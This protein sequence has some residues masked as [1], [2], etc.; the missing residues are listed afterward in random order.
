MEL[1]TLTPAQRRLVDGLLGWSDPRPLA[2]DDQIERLRRELADGV[3]AILD[4][5][6]DG[7]SVFVGKTGLDRLACDGWW[8]DL[9]DDRFVWGFQTAR[10][11]LA[12]AAIEWDWQLRRGWPP[13]VPVARAW[14]Q[15]ATGGDSLAR[16]LN[17]LDEVDATALRHQAEQLTTDLR[18]TWPLLPSSAHLRTEARIRV[19]LGRGRI[20]LQGTPDLTLGGIRDDRARM[21]LVDFKTGLPRP[22][23]ERQALRF[24][25]LLA[26]LKYGRSPFR[27]A[28]YYVAEGRWDAEDATP[29]LLHGA[30]RRLIAGIE[31]AVRLRFTGD[32]TLELHGGDHCRWCS[33]QDTCHASATQGAG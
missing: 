27:W 17:G 30:L 9:Q 28:T 33:R 14:N 5:I 19:E 8:L 4:R 32:G 22:G 18:D 23:P 10:G 7:E 20:V 26:A 12:H 11:R 29:E 24:Y 15:L 6:P 25:G 1:G 16:Y 3:A 31:Q 21:L 2:D 13:D